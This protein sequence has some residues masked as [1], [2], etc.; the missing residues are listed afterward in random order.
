MLA[1]FT[2]NYTVV[3]L[4]YFYFYAKFEKNIIWVLCPLASFLIFYTTQIG[5]M[6]MITRNLHI[7]E[8]NWMWAQIGY[9]EEFEIKRFIEELEKM[10]I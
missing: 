3:V 8:I 1:K 5:M 4:R 10:M 2:I 9:Q 7:C 6:T